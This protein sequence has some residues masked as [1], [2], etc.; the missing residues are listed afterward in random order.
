LIG[1]AE[2]IGICHTLSA[3]NTEGK[4]AKVAASFVGTWKLNVAKSKV[5]PDLPWKRALNTITAQDNRLKVVRDN[6]DGEGKAE[7]A[8][9]L[10]KYDGTDC[11]VSGNSN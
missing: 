11:P 6:V 4:A 9:Y 8:E 2:R 10:L 1:R 5:N 3:Q 7:H